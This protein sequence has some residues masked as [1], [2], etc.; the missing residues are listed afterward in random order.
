[1]PAMQTI[2]WGIIGC[3]DVTEVKSGPAFQKADGS[4]LVAVMR[5]DGAKAEDYARR[6]GVPRWYDDADKLIADAE[7]SA[8]YVATPPGSHEEYAL[9]V[10]RAGKPCYVEKPMARTGAEARRMTQAF[11]DGGLPLY[12]AYYRRRMERFQQARRIIQSGRLGPIRSVSYLYRD[13]QMSKRI[14]PV[15][16]RLQAEHSGGG[17]FLDLGSHALDLLDFF[18]GPLRFVAGD[19]RSN[20]KTYDVED[21]VE[22][23]FTAS[24][25]IIGSAQWD[26]TSSETDDRYE[27]TGQRATL[28]F[29]CFGSEPLVIEFGGKIIE[30]FEF[31][32]PAHVQQGL[33]QAIVN[34]LRGDESAREW[35][36]TGAAGQRTQEIMER[37]I[38]RFH[39]KR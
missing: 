7:V 22:L 8:V 32:R 17:L 5:R 36:S 16:W 25:N 34:D 31:P 4:A 27:I 28:R 39:A 2:R 11:A 1:M 26:F 3:G 14:E 23:T 30:Q 21:Q 20:A 12:I 19:A 24:G 15:P 9:K 10:C 18:F 38:E 6:H 35:I 33:I 37:A 29:S 13:G